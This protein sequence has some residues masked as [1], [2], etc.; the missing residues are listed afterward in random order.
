MA[1]ID[2]QD[3]L[4]KVGAAPAGPFA[5]IEDMTSYSGT[6]GNEGEARR[7][8][9]GRVSPYVR[10]GANTDE[11]SLSGLYNPDDTGG[12]NVLRSARDNRTTV[13]LQVLP[14]GV[15]GYQQE[16]NVTEYSEN[17][18]ADG[19]YVEAAF[20]LTAVGPRTSVGA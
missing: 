17:G 10:A 16:C 3:S 15:S 19:D 11:Y 2:V 12:Q 4:I 1:I 8:V 9:F 18:D 7:R 14:N 6:H 5:T 13:I 20:S